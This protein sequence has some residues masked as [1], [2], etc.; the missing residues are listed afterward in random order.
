M[1]SAHLLPGPT[2]W[3]AVGFSEE[4]PPGGTLI[5]TLAGREILL[6]RTDSGVPAAVAPHCP[7]LGAHIGHG[8]VVHGET[9]RCPFHG[10]CFDVRGNCVKNGYGT[11][12]HPNAVL[13]TWP[14]R[15]LHGML[16]VYLDGTGEQPAWEIPDIDT[17]GWTPVRHHAIHMRGHVQEIAENSCDIGHLRLLHG[18]QNV[19]MLSDLRTDGPYLNVRYRMTRPRRTFGRSQGSVVELE[20]H[21]Y[22]LGYARVEVLAVDLGVRTRHFVLAAPIDDD[23]VVLRLA[24]SVQRVHRPSMIHPLLALAPRTWTTGLVATM[25]IKGFVADVMQDVPIWTHKTFVATPALMKGDGPIGA[26]RKWT[27]QFYP[28]QSGVGDPPTP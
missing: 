21:Q 2:S 28:D 14:M 20:I 27:K 6:F 26:Y 10:A 19:E 12:P 15:E 4:L 25:G 24:L 23:Q 5:R 11:T 18:Y 3:Y 7:H 8:G 17:E 22:G 1:Y 16:F 9:I 13:T